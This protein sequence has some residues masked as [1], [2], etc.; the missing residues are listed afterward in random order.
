MN[1]QGRVDTFY[2][3]HSCSISVPHENSTLLRYQYLTDRVGMEYLQAESFCFSIYNKNSTPMIV[4]FSVSYYSTPAPTPDGMTGTIIAVSVIGV[5]FLV[6][7]LVGLLYRFYYGRQKKREGYRL[8]KQSIEPLS[9]Q[10]ESSIED[11]IAEPSINPFRHTGLEEG[12][13]DKY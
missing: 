10:E 13:S 2:A 9:L 3:P 12:F 11:S 7:G 8:V 5:A 1:A 6:L 4:D